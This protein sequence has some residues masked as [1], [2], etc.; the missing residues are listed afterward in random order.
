MKKGELIQKG[1]KWLHGYGESD[2]LIEI[3]RG[4]L[5]F[6]IGFVGWLLIH[7]LQ[8]SNAVIWLLFFLVAFTMW[9]LDEVRLIVIKADPTNWFI[10][11][12]K[13]INNEWVRRILTRGMEDST[14]TTILRSV[15]GLGIA[16]AIA[17]RWIAVC[18]GL[19]FSLV[20]PLAKL[21]IY[22]PVKKFAE[23]S[24]AYGKSLGGCLFGFLGGFIAVT[25][26]ICWH[27]WSIPLFPANISIIQ[28]VIVYFVGSVSAPFFELYS[29]KQD[30]IAIPAGTAILMAL[31]NYFFSLFG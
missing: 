26:L 19:L 20:D 10:R 17:P 13:W 21:G 14:R 25:W 4:L 24:R 11:L 30:N 16:W 18:S 29:G 7:I 9:I 15:V 6:S 28:V 5:H 27:W 22:W 3:G 8:L 1:K 12:L 2:A 31:T 23:N